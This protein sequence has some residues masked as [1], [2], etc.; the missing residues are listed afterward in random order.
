MPIEPEQ[1]LTGGHKRL[2][3]ELEAAS[4]ATSYFSDSYSLL[5]SCGVAVDL[6]LGSLVASGN[7]SEKQPSRG[8]M[9]AFPSG[10]TTRH[11]TLLSY[12]VTRQ[13][14][15]IASADRWRNTD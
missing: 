5:F 4:T 10:A 12:V 8:Y 15:R 9:T 2:P 11:A 14:K 3:T 7:G 6:L 1:G 13:Y